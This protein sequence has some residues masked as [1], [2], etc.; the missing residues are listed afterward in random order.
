MILMVLQDNQ[1]HQNYQMGLLLICLFG[2]DSHYTNM[3]YYYHNQRNFHHNLY[4]FYLKSVHQLLFQKMIMLNWSYLKMSLLM[5]LIS[6]NFRRYLTLSKRSFLTINTKRFWNN[7]R[8]IAI[9]SRYFN[10]TYVNNSRIVCIDIVSNS[11]RC[12]TSYYAILDDNEKNFCHIFR[13]S[14]WTWPR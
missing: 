4:Q 6:R 9:Y 13:S 12:V 1:F 11:F 10:S 3:S 14:A 7:N 2:L 5:E 8:N